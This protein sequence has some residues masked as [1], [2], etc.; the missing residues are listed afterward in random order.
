MRP[1]T[2]FELLRPRTL[3]GALEIMATL[4]GA[5]PIAGG[6]DLIPTFRDLGCK[7]RNLVDLGLIPE[8]NYV[9]EDGRYVNIG[10]TTT[11]AQL[12][13][14]NLIR[15]KAQALHDA[16]DVLG[17]VQIRNRGTIGGNLC[18]ASPAADTAPP[19]LVLDAEVAVSS[20]DDSRWMSLQELFAGPKTTTLDPDE[21]LTGIRFPKTE[22]SGSAFHRLCRRRGFTL[23]VVNAAAYVEREGG[24]CRSVRI[25]LGSVA[26]TPVR[27]DEAEGELEGKRMTGALIDEAAEACR[28][29]V[30][31]IDDVRGT[32]E[33][34]RDMSAVLV[35][36]ALRE[37]WR[38]A[39]GEL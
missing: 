15:E 21:L 17:S 26:P 23:S 7:H 8:L 37:A 9:F 32:A 33:Y 34:R 3:V 22:G 10:P 39:G 31:P 6:T 25:A 20:L 29:H 5:Q 28:E 30:S 35:R 38:R 19:L 12:Q 14:T 2:G 4:E 36:R 16:V 24:T 1:L 13:A 27:I 11:H 18:N